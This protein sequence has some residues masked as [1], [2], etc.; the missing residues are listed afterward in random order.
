LPHLPHPHCQLL[1]VEVLREW[2]RILSRLS[3]ELLELLCRDCAVTLEMRGQASLQRGHVLARKEQ[4]RAYTQEP[5]LANQPCKDFLS[6]R[7]LNLSGGRDLSDAW[8]R[9]AGVDVEPDHALPEIVVGDACLVRG[10]ANE[11]FVRD[12]LARGGQHVEDAM[13][14]LGRDSARK[15]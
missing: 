2:D 9:Q 14:Q 4:L 12:E 8:R 15:A 1:G 7:W 11:L 6:P 5:A 10:A 13:E 3:R